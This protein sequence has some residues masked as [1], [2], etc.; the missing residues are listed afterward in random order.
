M[1]DAWRSGYRGILPQ[2]FLDRLDFADRVDVWED[3]IR[4]AWNDGRPVDGPE[5][6]PEM[7]VADRSGEVVGV[8]TVGASRDESVPDGGELWMLNVAAAHWGS[9]VGTALLDTARHALEHRGF[10]R[11]LLW[12]F[13]VNERA[14]SLY[15]RSGWQPDGATRHL[16][17]ADQELLEIRMRL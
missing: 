9:G 16:E 15:E 17:I 7:F 6:G 10:H 14:R 13:E 1:A 3:S 8:T 11:P 2:G 5:H 4:A 12:V